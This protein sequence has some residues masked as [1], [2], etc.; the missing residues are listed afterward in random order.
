[1]VGYVRRPE[2]NIHL[3][4]EKSPSKQALKPFYKDVSAESK[5][6]R[7]DDGSIPFETIKNI[8]YKSH[9]G[10]L[11]RDGRNLHLVKND[12]DVLERD[13]KVSVD[14][15]AL[16]EY[17]LDQYGNKN[18]VLE[19]SEIFA[20]IVLSNKDYL[21]T[22][23][24]K[25]EL[26]KGLGVKILDR[27]INNDFVA[28]LENFFQPDRDM[29]GEST[30]P[31]V[32]N[33]RTNKAAVNYD[34][35]LKDL[36]QTYQQ[37][38][39]N[40]LFKAF[41][42]MGIM[43]LGRK[44][45]Y[46]GKLFLEI[47][48]SKAERLSL[49]P[50]EKGSLER[51]FLWDHKS[52]VTIE[53]KENSQVAMTVELPQEKDLRGHHLLVKAPEQYLTTINDVK[54]WLDKKIAKAEE[55][56]R[57]NKEVLKTFYE[58][59]PSMIEN[60]DLFTAR[61]LFPIANL[62]SPVYNEKDEKNEDKYFNTSEKEAGG[63]VGRFIPEDKLVLV[64][65]QTFENEL[66]NYKQQG[67]SQ[68]EIQTALFKLLINTLS[69]EFFHAYQED[70]VKNGLSAQETSLVRDYVEDLESVGGVNKYNKY[71]STPAVS[72]I[73]TGDYDKYYRDQPDE[74]AA[75]YIGDTLAGKALTLVLDE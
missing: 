3:Y 68:E 51:F 10:A 55:C 44:R 62:F 15:L 43:P 14:E 64:Y 39:K 41:G 48:L 37:A 22:E 45:E 65:R 33:I 61:A 9:V 26:P 66:K 46:E 24:E 34:K 17:R 59:F 18:G 35:A 29:V 56:M 73:L 2:F 67:C 36:P 8:L 31:Q 72:M 32:V 60:P 7:R 71:Y 63:I 4:G 16:Y 58:K 53:E 12:I 6:V 54:P 69:H 11:S 47:L 25:A 28:S 50:Q 75:Y 74:A 20:G 52:P 42:Q 27:L 23:S 1:M 49:E 57:A 21:Y 40:V 38:F 30:Q 13:N 5:G 19:G 70:L